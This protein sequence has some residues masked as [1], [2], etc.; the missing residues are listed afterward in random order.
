MLCAI[1]DLHQQGV[2]RRLL[3]SRSSS[4]IGESGILIPLLAIV[5]DV[6]FDIYAKDSDLKCI[7][8]NNM[9]SSTL[10]QPVDAENLEDKHREVL[11]TG[12]VV[13]VETTVHTADGPQ[14]IRAMKFPITVN[15][16]SCVAGVAYRIDDH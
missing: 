1:E 14:R 16:R 2:V 8:A 3:I 11:R 9:V 15:G 12:R 5:D 13:T 10:G 4:G 7:D 6:P